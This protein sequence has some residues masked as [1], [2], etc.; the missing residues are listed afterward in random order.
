MKRKLRYNMGNE[1]VEKDVNYIPI[2][3][4]LAVTLA[5]LETLAI[6]AI[7]VL[8]TIL[9]VYQEN[10]ASNALKALKEMGL[11]AQLGGRNDMTIEG[12]KFSGNSQYVKSGRIM[13]HGTLMFD[14]DLEV[15]AS[16]L[17]VSADKIESK[18]IKSV[19]ARVT[20]IREHMNASAT[21]SEFEHRLVSNVFRGEEINEYILTAEDIAAAEKLKAEKY[22]TWQWNFGQSP[23]YTHL[24]ERR[25]EGVGTVKLY[26]EVREGKIGSL[27]CHGDYFGAEDATALEQ[28]LVGTE[29]NEAAVRSVMDKIDPARYF[30]NIKKEDFIKILTD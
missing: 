12:K 30:H 14:S 25:I 24:K 28:A 6:I 4:I 7:V 16:A 15:V 29:L 23:R 21:L 19:R 22:G 17:K 1:T 8:N 27:K 9:G 10:K 26:L 2:R 5:V 18:G 3:F 20:N 13:H 11:E